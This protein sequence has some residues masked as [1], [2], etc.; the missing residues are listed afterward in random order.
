MSTISEAAAILYSYFTGVSDGFSSQSGKKLFD[1]MLEYF[2][3]KNS[4]L[5]N[6]QNV[7]LLEDINRESIGINEIISTISELIKDE[8]A[9]FT[10]ELCSKLDSFRSEESLN[11]R[12]YS[13]NISSAQY[14][15]QSEKTNIIHNVQKDLNIQM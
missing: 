7:S 6:C 4:A 9:E 12:Y 8:K 2:K 3:K 10:S 13:G 1:W 15:I 5:G 11:E 14:S